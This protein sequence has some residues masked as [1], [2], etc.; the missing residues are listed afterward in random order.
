[1][2]SAWMK[3]EYEQTLFL[4]QDL[5]QVPPSFGVVTACNPDGVTVS[6]EQ[7]MA[8]SERLERHLAEAGFQYF[9]VTGCSPDLTHQE[10]GFGII[11]DDRDVIIE[12]GRE[13]R[14]EAV[15]W[16]DRGIV[17]LVPC[18][19][20]EAVNLGRWTARVVRPG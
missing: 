18:G 7:N 20:G 8:A 13:W 1:M 14:Q 6:N 17:H 12:L 3:R 15:Y 9:P 19:G 11:T 10:P 5:A 16:I 2:M 4:V